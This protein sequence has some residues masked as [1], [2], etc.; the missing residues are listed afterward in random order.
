M[1]DEEQADREG[2]GRELAR[3]YQAEVEREAWGMCPNCGGTDWFEL[4]EGTD[5]VEVCVECGRRVA[6]D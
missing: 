1:F 4:V 5:W 2:E 3:D 6:A